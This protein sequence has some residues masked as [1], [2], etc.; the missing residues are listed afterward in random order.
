MLVCIDS[1]CSVIVVS[2]SKSC[3]E[4]STIT[5]SK[6]HTSRD[7]LTFILEINYKGKSVK[8]KIKK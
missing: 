8:N 1:R 7:V 2:R 4:S 5:L 3:C 6:K